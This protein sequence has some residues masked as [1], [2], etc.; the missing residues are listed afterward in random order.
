MWLYFLLFFFVGVFVIHEAHAV[1]PKTSGSHAF[2]N[3]S[4]S[5][6]NL[7][8]KD[9][10]VCE[11]WCDLFCDFSSRTGAAILSICIVW[12]GG[13]I[14]LP[15]QKPRTKVYGFNGMFICCELHMLACVPLSLCYIYGGI[16]AVC[17]ELWAGTVRDVAFNQLLPD[18][19]SS[20]K[21]LKSLHTRA[22]KRVLSGMQFRCSLVP[23]MVYMN[24]QHIS[25]ST[26]LNVNF[27]IPVVAQPALGFHMQSW[28]DCPG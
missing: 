11:H 27:V 26:H 9:V 23:Y 21:H 6:Y 22:I 2:V 8:M 14:S 13:S 28:T 19:C 16:S 15:F 10:G 7:N 18:L 3:L 20:L 25:M 1:K 5:D 4:N 12:G 24:P 17:A